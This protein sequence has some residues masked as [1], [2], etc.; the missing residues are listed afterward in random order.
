MSLYRH[1]PYCTNPLPIWAVVK[2]KALNT[3]APIFCPSCNSII[4]YCPS[5][6]SRATYSGVGIAFG[7][8]VAK[9]THAISGGSVFLDL[10]LGTLFL[11]GIVL[12]IYYFAHVKDG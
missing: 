3:D 1:C 10:L 9:V 2:P 11:V 5:K 4:S 6:R 12:L 7:Y 8:L